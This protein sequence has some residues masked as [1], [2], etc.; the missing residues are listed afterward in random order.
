MSS[1]GAT[2]FM[3]RSKR[4]WV[5]ISQT[6]TLTAFATLGRSLGQVTWAYPFLSFLKSWEEYKLTSETLT[7]SE[8]PCGSTVCGLTWLTLHCWVLI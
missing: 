2:I 1:L 4:I 3:I 8:I 7:A 6:L 5:Y